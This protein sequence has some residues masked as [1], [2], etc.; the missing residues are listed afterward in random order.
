MITPIPLLAS[1]RKA[2][3]HG[4]PGAG[5][6][7]KPSSLNHTTHLK[8]RLCLKTDVSGRERFV[9][10][11]SLL[12]LHSSILNQISGG[13]SKVKTQSPQKRAGTRAD[14][15]QPSSHKHQTDS[16]VECLGP[17]P[18]PLRTFSGFAGQQTPQNRN[19]PLGS[20][21]LQNSKIG[22]CL[23]SL[24]TGVIII[25]DANHTIRQWRK[26]GIWGSIERRT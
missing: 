17:T 3:H 16:S 5:R 4:T 13:S 14:A 10:R 21:R 25:A 9:P 1:R 7:G 15:R 19:Q 24:T 23:L 11:P 22:G 18:Q 26:L 6:Q 20:A 8:A 2:S 12:A